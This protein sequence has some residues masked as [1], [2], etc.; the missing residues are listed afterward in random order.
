M[1]KPLSKK[2]SKTYQA[3][4]KSLKKK[5]DKIKVLSYREAEEIAFDATHGSPKADAVVLGKY[6]DGGPTSYT[7]IA[8]EMDAQYFQLDNWQEIAEAYSEDE[9][10][11]INE[12]FL[13]I[14]TSSGREIYLSHNPNDYINKTD[15]YS[16]E[17]RYLVENGYKFVKKGDLWHA[18]R[19]RV[20]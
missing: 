2:S 10:W 9:I 17:L 4:K 1:T 13:D 16:R 14:Q 12:R 15:F 8:K 20:L 7:S 11:K 19:Q 3:G 18:I 5:A 6:G